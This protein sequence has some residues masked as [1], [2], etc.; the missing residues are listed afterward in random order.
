MDWIVPK[1]PFYKSQ[2]SVIIQYS[3]ISV[4][5]RLT[6]YET[7]SKFINSLAINLILHSFLTLVIREWKK[8]I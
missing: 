6:N 4:V 2:T 8:E 7:F 1:L 3:Q 5:I